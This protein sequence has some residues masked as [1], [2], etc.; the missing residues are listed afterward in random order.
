MYY[1]SL[2]Y[3]VMAVLAL[4][5]LSSSKLSNNEPN[6]GQNTSVQTEQTGQTFR[7]ICTSAPS[8]PYTAPVTCPASSRH[9]IRPQART[10]HANSR[11]M[12]NTHV[13]W[14]LEVTRCCCSHGLPVDRYESADVTKERV[15]NNSFAS[16]YAFLMSLV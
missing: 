16:S 8:P 14:T 9:V 7:N 11:S 5:S 2:M 4:A 1:G 12:M 10:Q 6:E 13:P 3:A 15:W